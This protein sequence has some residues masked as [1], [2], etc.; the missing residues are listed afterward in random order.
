MGKVVVVKLA[1]FALDGPLTT[2]SGALRVVTLGT[3]LVV[4]TLGGSPGWKGAPEARPRLC[5]PF[6]LVG[7]LASS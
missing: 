6:I 4:E 5:V 2:C 7:D 3:E 1:A